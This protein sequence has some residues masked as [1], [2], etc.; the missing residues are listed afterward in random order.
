MLAGVIKPHLILFFLKG[1]RTRKKA[2]L[3]FGALSILFFT[4]FGLITELPNSLKTEPEKKISPTGEEKFL[5]TFQRKSSSREELPEE[6]KKCQSGAAPCNM[7][8]GEVAKTELL[9]LVPWT[10]GAVSLS[11]PFDWNVFTGGECATKSILARDPS[12]E[13]KQVFYFSQ[14]G[15]VYTS[16]EQK[17]R[18]YSYM[19]MGGY[20]ITWLKSPVVNPVTADNYLMN[21]SDLALTG[22]FQQAF[23][24]VP[25]MTNVKIISSQEVSNKP[26]Y[27]T[28]AK[29]IRAEFKQNN[30][31]GE[32]Y[33]YIATADMQIGLGYGMVF[34]GV[35]APRGLLDLITPSL[36]KSLDSYAVNQ[37]YVNT[38][39]NANNKAAAGALKA[40]KILSE[41]SDTIMDVWEN[42]LESEQ[43]MSEKQ[44]DAILGFSRLYNPDTDEVYEITPEFYDYYQAHDDEFEMNYL[45]SL[46]DDK[47]NHTPLNGAEHIR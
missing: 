28:D 4:L 2:V 1:A 40:G 46:P 9:Q 36:K 16:Q 24:R 20:N 30:K 6:S 22:F 7:S 17:T 15:P 33:F 45:E 35:T 23:P 42:K 29:L 27:A 39:I 11:I 38:C 13:L 3:I 21:F 32:G 14:A 44:S 43:R 25:I 10:D 12:S 19:K 8:I 18:D 37:D 47:W 31:S 26:A 5:E 41:T 34:I